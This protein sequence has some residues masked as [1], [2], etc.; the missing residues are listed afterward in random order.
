MGMWSNANTRKDL[1]DRLGLGDGRIIRSLEQD[2]ELMDI[3]EDPRRTRT[4]MS[5]KDARAADQLLKQGKQPRKK[6]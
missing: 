5:K 4:R 2:E 1:R 3:G 6:R